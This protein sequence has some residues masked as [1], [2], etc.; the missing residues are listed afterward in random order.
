MINC[1]VDQLVS[2]V[3]KALTDIGMRQLEVT[4]SSADYLANI[5]LPNEYLY[6]VSRRPIDSPGHQKIR[7]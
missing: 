7:H 3:F 5:D 2:K 4:F 1:W 6:H